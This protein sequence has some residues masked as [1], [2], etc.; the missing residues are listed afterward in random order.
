[1]AADVTI[2][3]KTKESFT[4]E[5][6][7]LNAFNNFTLEAYLWYLISLMFVFLIMVVHRRVVSFESA[8]RYAVDIAIHIFSTM[9]DHE[10]LPKKQ[11]PAQSVI[12][13]AFNCAHFVIAFGYLCN[14]ISTDKIATVIPAQIDSLRDLISTEFNDTQPMIMK[15]LFLF[16]YLKQ[17]PKESDLGQ[18]FAKLEANKMASY[19]EFSKEMIWVLPFMDGSRSISG[20]QHLAVYGAS[21]FCAIDAKVASLF[22]M[23]KH[24]FAQGI[25]TTFMN[26]HANP[27]AKKVIRTR[28]MSIFEMGT[29]TGFVHNWKLQIVEVGFGRKSS[30]E[31]LECEQRVKNKGIK[32]G[33]EYQEMALK[34]LHQL[35]PVVIASGLLVSFLISA[36]IAHAK[37]AGKLKKLV[38]VCRKLSRYRFRTL[39]R[40]TVFICSKDRYCLKLGLVQNGETTNPRLKGL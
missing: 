19:I 16:D 20:L 6:G 18:L 23:S 4:I 12:W 2:V 14:F 33:F 13:L 25:L 24:L 26:H 30:L 11:R 7:V 10:Q 29:F 32:K 36:E 8:F 1:M 22:R 31:A 3:S 40:S 15:D 38:P 39:H 5:T 27:I 9:V 35:F 37:T 34:S 17:S 28:Y 21:S